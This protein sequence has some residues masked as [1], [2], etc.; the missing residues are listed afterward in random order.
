MLINRLPHSALL[1]K[2]V[3]A[4]IEPSNK[5]HQSV[6]RKNVEH[7]RYPQFSLLREAVAVLDKGTELDVPVHRKGRY[8]CIVLFLEF[9]MSN[10]TASLGIIHEKTVAL[11]RTYDQ[12]QGP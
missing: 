12:I 2:V 7:L 6:A 10:T 8:A 5:D 1:L 9:P 4:I 11:R 3:G